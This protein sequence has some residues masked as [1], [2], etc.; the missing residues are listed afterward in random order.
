M[1]QGAR[2]EDERLRPDADDLEHHPAANKATGCICR[3]RVFL[4][5][6]SQVRGRKGRAVRVGGAPTAEGQRR[7]Q[8]GPH[9]TSIARLRRR[10]VLRRK[11]HPRSIM[12]TTVRRK[13]SCTR[14][15]GDRRGRTGSTA[16]PI[17]NATALPCNP[18]SRDGAGEHSARR[19]GLSRISQM[20]QERISPVCRGP[21]WAQIPRNPGDGP[22]RC[23]A[24]PSTWAA[25][26]PQ[27]RA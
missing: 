26:R 22:A 6:T 25:L 12:S 23:S 19:P 1:Q 16:L 5:E 4:S 18:P 20:H 8:G 13:A 2:L 21:P 10:R 17:F 14:P 24:G 3:K 9:L 7:E 15:S 11:S 27:P